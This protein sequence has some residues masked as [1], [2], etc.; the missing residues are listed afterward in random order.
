ML[1]TN[2]DTLVRES[3]TREFA[4]SLIS[5]AKTQKRLAHEY[6]RMAVTSADLNRTEAYQRNKAEANRLWRDAK[7]H[8]Q[9]ARRHLARIAQ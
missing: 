7:W 6:K 3:R 1:H 9:C 2:P 5:L 4:L 8:L